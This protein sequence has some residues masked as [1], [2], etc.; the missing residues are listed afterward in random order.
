MANCVVHTGNSAGVNVRSAKETGSAT[1]LG[2]IDNGV[3]VNVVRCDGTW[4]SLMY[5][6]S[7]A[8]VQHQY[9]NNPPTINGDGLSVNDYGTCNGTNVNVR[10]AANGSSIVGQINKNESYKILAKSLTNSYYWY[11]IGTNQWVRGDFFAPS[12]GGTSGGTGGGSTSYTATICQGDSTDA[13]D[14]RVFY[15]ELSSVYSNVQ[16]VAFSP[17]SNTPTGTA[18]ESDFRAARNYDVLYWSS[19]GSSTPRLN[20]T[21]GPAFASLDSAESYWN[22]TTY[23]LKVPI[24]AACYQLDGSTNRSR[25]AN[26]MRNSNIRVLCGYHEGAPGHPDRKSVV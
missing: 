10:N 26:V 13:G 5:N 15:N 20:V 7:P 12:S 1:L 19:H 14:C 22:G 25:W 16:N 9:L 2:V 8:F 3:T 18:T 24:I 4:A 6:G 21:G 11:R 23:K 17:S